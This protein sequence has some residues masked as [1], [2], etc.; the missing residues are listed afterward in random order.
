[1]HQGRGGREEE[2]G[3]RGKGRGGR[4]EKEGVQVTHSEVVGVFIPGAVGIA[5]GS[6][7]IKG[8]QCPKR[9]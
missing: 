7:I 8:K 2:E 4:G 6:T 9:E 5:E 1:M 3:K